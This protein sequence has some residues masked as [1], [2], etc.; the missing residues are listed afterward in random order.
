M[1]LMSV[2]FQISKERAVVTGRGDLTAS[3]LVEAAAQVYG[4][5]QFRPGMSTLLDVRGACPAVTGDEVRMIVSF[6]SRNLEER[7][8]GSC[9]IVT[10][11]SVD[12]GMARMG[13][14]L[15]E[16]LGIELM[17]FRELEDAE[18]WLDGKEERE[19]RAP[20]VE[21]NQELQYGAE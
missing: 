14:V 18:R 15:M 2:A 11:R 10:D 8:K 13:Q 6:V 12:Y 5:P 3:D 19:A 17:V 7:G 1:G 9:A 4:D 20:S 16:A 21:A